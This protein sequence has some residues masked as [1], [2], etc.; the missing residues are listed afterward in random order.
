MATFE[1][2]KVLHGA[3]HLKGIKQFDAIYFGSEKVG[4]EFMMTGLDPPKLNWS[5]PLPVGPESVKYLSKLSQLPKNGP[6]RL[7]F[8]QEYFESPEDLLA[9]DAFDE[10]A[11]APY[12]EVVGLKDR[13]H[14][15]KLVGWIQ[16]NDV[17]ASRRRLYL[18][19]LGVC[20]TK[21]DLPMLEAMIRSEDRETKRALDA[22]IA[23]DLLLGG[24]ERLPLI[25]DLFLKDPNADYTDTY[26]AIMALRFHGQE[27]D[28]IPKQRLVESMRHMLDRPKLADL[29]IPDLARWQDWESIDRLTTLFKES[30]EESS[31]VR[32]PVI[33]FLKACPLPAAKQALDELAVIDPDAMKRASSFLP[34]AAAAPPK[35]QITSPGTSKPDATLTETPRTDDP[36]TPVAATDP[37]VKDSAATDATP[38]E[39]PSAP[40][41]ETE[42]DA[43]SETETVAQSAAASEQ[44][45]VGDAPA[46]PESATSEAEADSDDSGADSDDSG[47][48]STVSQQPVGPIAPDPPIDP[49]DDPPATAHGEGAAS[50]SASPSYVGMFLVGGALLLAALAIVFLLRG[51]RHGSTA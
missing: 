31:W 30:D 9:R 37:A 1:I 35:E 5:T 2:V 22:L 6:D 48:A 10:F 27:V 14:H 19:M 28:N 12:A 43:M 36:S 34:F 20:G 49:S 46:T 11:K 44:P 15:D 16:S 13:M 21:D 45:A 24:A 38:L 47:V 18:T 29:V 26:A 40:A 3:E 32:V 7:A 33:N 25:E 17:P 8:F 41:P 42:P 23:C 51:Q 4:T 39:V 50:A